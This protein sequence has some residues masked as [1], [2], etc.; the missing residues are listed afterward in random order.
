[1]HLLI[2]VQMSYVY[3]KNQFL[4]VNVTL[5]ELDGTL[6]LFIYYFALFCEGT[7]IE[8]ATVK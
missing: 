6:D 2:C 8:V 7:I 5:L 4:S 3:L 1:M